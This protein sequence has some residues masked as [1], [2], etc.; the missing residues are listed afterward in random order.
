MRIRLLLTVLALFG[1]RLERVCQLYYGVRLG[2]LLSFSVLMVSGLVAGD[3]FSTTYS[4][5]RPSV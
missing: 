5:F 4:H 3:L 1:G 2:F